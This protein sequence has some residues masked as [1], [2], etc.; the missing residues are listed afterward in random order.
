MFFLRVELRLQLTQENALR[1]VKKSSPQMLALSR[2]LFPDGEN[3]IA[4]EKLE[5]QWSLN[6]QKVRAIF[7]RV[8]DEL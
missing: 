6:T 5:E 1:V 2:S 8:R 7:E 3:S 4:Q